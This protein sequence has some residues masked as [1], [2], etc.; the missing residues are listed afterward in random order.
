[1][2]SR[3]IKDMTLAERVAAMESLWDSITAE[4]CAPRSPVWHKKVLAERKE[5]LLGHDAKFVTLAQM[6]KRLAS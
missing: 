6:R 3:Q 1:M 4:K 5:K 2:T